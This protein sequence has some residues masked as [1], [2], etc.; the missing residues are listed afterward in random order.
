MSEKKRSIA[1]YFVPSKKSKEDTSEVP[2][3][4]SGVTVNTSAGVVESGTVSDEDYDDTDDSTTEDDIELHDESDSEIP[5]FVEWMSERSQSGSSSQQRSVI[6]T[7]AKPGPADLSQFV[8]DGPKQPGRQFYPKTRFA[9]KLRQFNKNW[10]NLFPWVEYSITADAV[11]CFACRHFSTHVEVDKT[12]FINVGFKNWKKAMDQNAGLKLHNVSHEHKNSM[13]KWASF[14]EI[15]IRDTNVQ[16]V[17]AQVNEAHLNLVKE[18]RAYL[19]II[20]DILIYT[21]LQCIPQRGDKEGIESSNRGN[22]LELLT[23]FGKYNEIVKK[24]FLAD[25]AAKNA[26]YT[27]PLI[28]NQLLF[29]I[30]KM[31]LDQ[32]GD[33]IRKVSCFAVICDETKDISKTEQLSVVIRYY[34]E[35]AIHERFIGFRPA[36]ELNAQSLLEYI[37]E[38]LARCSID[39]NKCVAQTYDGANVMSGRVNGV[40]KLLRDEVENALYVHCYNHRLNLVVVDICKNLPSG[41]SF[42]GLVE[43]LYVFISGSAVHS[44]FVQIQKDLNPNKKV[45]EL[46]RICHVRWTA[47]VFACISLKSVLG[48][49][50]VL[51]NKI[52]LNRDDRASEAIG[53]LHQ[54]DFNF[55]FNLCLYSKILTIFKKV[56]DFLQKVTFNLTEANILIESIVSSFSDMRTDSNSMVFLELFSE[57]KKICSDN[58]INIRPITREK[59]IPKKFASY[60]ITEEIKS[61]ESSTETNKDHFKVEIFYPVVDV[62]LSELDR[63]FKKNSSVICAMDVLHPQNA[64]FLNFEHLKPMAE[65]YGCNMDILQCELKILPT[66]IKKYEETVKTKVANIMDFIDIL[67]KYDLVFPETL[68]LAV[69]VVTIPVSSAACERTFSSLKRIKTYLRNRMTDERLGH[70]AIINIERAAVKRLETTKIVDE[71][72]ACHENRRIILH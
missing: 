72:D 33:D 64:N 34:L 70:L 65:H 51:L 54:M 49:L 21:A 17:A 36:R 1:D 58:N 15:K 56:S 28:Q 24:K 14:K 60:F 8:L 11:F 4:S 39:I 35:G 68:K 23:L 45:I 62:I 66:T 2:S 32:I 18:N 7:P 52:I 9:N 38:L 69:I 19:G 44:K 31:L 50:L 22:F 10:Y 42:F 43:N 40:Q 61:L 41:N 12:I 6:I 13:I 57:A 30:S 67:T 53:L 27:S 29:V 16:S 5:Q 55:V 3:T 71:F 46:K 37:E 59:K 25:E 20:V 48:E 63:R 26:R 47:Q